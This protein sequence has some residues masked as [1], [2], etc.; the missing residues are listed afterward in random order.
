[1]TESRCQIVTLCEHKGTYIVGNNN[2]SEIVD[3][4]HVPVGNI[5]KRIKKR[6]MKIKHRRRIMLDDKIVKLASGEKESSGWEAILMGNMM[7]S[8]PLV[9]RDDHWSPLYADT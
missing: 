2:T 9:I 3:R 5:K 4:P 7:Q 1:M 6:R 8:N